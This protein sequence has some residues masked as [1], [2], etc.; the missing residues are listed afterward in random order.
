MSVFRSAQ[1]R[2]AVLARYRGILEPFPLERRDVETRY[3]RTFV[4]EAGAKAAPPVVLLHG[5]CGN[6]AFWLGDIFPL[7]RDYRVLAVDIVGEAGLSAERRLDLES[8]AYARWLGAALDALGVERAALIGNSLGGWMALKFATA[9]PERVAKLALFGAS[10]VVPPSPLF[11]SEAL[12]GG[13]Q[14][15]A[16]EAAMQ[17]AVIPE[18]VL[19]FLR[20]IGD[21]F[22]PET[23][24]LPVFPDEA[25]RALTM[26]VLFA[27]GAL[28]K[29]MDPPAAAERVRAL[30]PRAEARLLEG[31]GHAILNIAEIALPFLAE[32]QELACVERNGRRVAVIDRW[33]R[34]A[35]PQDLLDQMA[36]A[37]SLGS[38]C[39]A[40]HRESLGEAF[41]DLKT[42]IA[43]EMLQKFSNYRTRLAVVGDFSNVQ[44]R[45][46]R[47]FIRESNR[48]GTVCFVDSLERALER[49]AAD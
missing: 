32:P 43:G 3:G 29:T 7:A 5:A 24:A 34:V 8:D 17:D 39:M 13:G 44:S 42:G 37:W 15:A 35:G 6:S 9:S 22:L 40:V 1:G 12:Q 45:S 38:R 19:E 48:G 41:F 26:P 30:L 2:E 23:R 47:D 49:L 18:P 33:S 20:L 11:R 28:D 27:A 10:G 31:Q 36:T 21:N 25:M 46:L 4:L 16:G 14:A